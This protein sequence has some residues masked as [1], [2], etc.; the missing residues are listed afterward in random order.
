[1]WCDLKWMKHE[2]IEE[3]PKFR[4]K[5]GKPVIEWRIPE[6]QN[7][8]NLSHHTILPC[9][10]HYQQVLVLVNDGWNW[11]EE[12]SFSVWLIFCACF[13]LNPVDSN[14][15]DNH[16]VCI[17]AYVLPVII[18]WGGCWVPGQEEVRCQWDR[19]D[20]KDPKTERP[21]EK[22]NKKRSVQS[23]RCRGSSI[24]RYAGYI[25]RTLVS[26]TDTTDRAGEKT[27]WTMSIPN[28]FYRPR[29]S[30]HVTWEGEVKCPGIY[31]PC[32]VYNDC[33]LQ[34]FSS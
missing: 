14:L 25:E 12:S 18:W 30:H 21:K 28:D 15:T 22:A 11:C 26:S 4:T 27:I 6:D 7:Q 2:L 8:G 1:L 29:S 9:Q 16:W 13:K 19:K 34:R 3:F 17:Y 31:C 23:I 24:L 32:R 10:I 33:R 20:G 5:E